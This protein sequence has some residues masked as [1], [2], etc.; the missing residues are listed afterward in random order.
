[1]T[2]LTV[3][4]SEEEYPD[5]QNPAGYRG[6]SDKRSSKEKGWDGVPYAKVSKKE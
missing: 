3:E 1:M 6:D 4:D 2:A 5:V